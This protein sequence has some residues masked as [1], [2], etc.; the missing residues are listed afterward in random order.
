MRHRRI[1]LTMG[2]DTDPTLL[3]LRGALAALPTLTLDINKAEG[4]RTGRPERMH[5]LLTI[6]NICCLFVAT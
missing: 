3:D 2:V 5:Q 1:Q 6:R 4:G